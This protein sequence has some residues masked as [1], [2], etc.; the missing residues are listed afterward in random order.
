MSEVR[1]RCP[2]CNKLRKGFRW[3]RGPYFYTSEWVGFTAVCQECGHEFFVNYKL[4]ECK[5]KPEVSE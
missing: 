2:K 3:I 4:A 1:M 5:N